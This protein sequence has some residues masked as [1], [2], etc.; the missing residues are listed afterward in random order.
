MRKKAKT[1]RL[2]ATLHQLLHWHKGSRQ[3]QEL[4]NGTTPIDEGLYNLAYQQISKEQKTEYSEDNAL[5]IARIMNQI[6]DNVDK[7]GVSFIQQYYLTKGLKLFKNDGK[8]AAIKELD[9]LVQRNCWTPVHVEELTR[10]EKDKATDSMML[11]A[12]KNSG[13]IKG[14]MVYKGNE[15]RDWLTREDTSSPTASTRILEPTPSI[16]SIDSVFSS[17]QLRALNAY[18]FEVSA[19]TGHKSITFPESSEVSVFSR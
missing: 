12:Q 5:V 13:K 3:K 14:R 2:T 4:L 1:K 18:G 8:N 10:E 16:T 6:H 11:L 7:K 9:Q 15:T 17:S 19:P